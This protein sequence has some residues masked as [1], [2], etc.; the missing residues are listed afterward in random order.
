MLVRVVWQKLTSAPEVRTV[1][2][3]SA[4]NKP[5]TKKR[6]VEEQQA[7]LS[8]NLSGQISPSEAS[9]NRPDQVEIC[10]AK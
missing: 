8:R 2:A 9:V 1:L 10:Q 6:L 4:V 3:I 7:R 5:R